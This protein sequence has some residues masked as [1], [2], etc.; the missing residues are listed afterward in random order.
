[1]RT[2][3]NYGGGRQTV[4]ICCLIVEGK[5]PQ[6]DRIVMADTNR[7]KGSTW[8]YLHQ[9]VQ[10]MLASIGMAVEVAPHSLAKVDLYSHNGDLLLPVFTATGKFSAYCSSEWKA[11]VVNRYLGGEDKKRIHWIGFSYDELKRVKSTE[12]KWFPLI[13]KM[14]TSYDCTFITARHG[15]PPAPRSACWMCPNMRNS[16]WRHVRDFLPEQFAMAC[17]LDDDIRAEDLANGGT[18]VWL[19]ATLVPLRDADLNARDS[20]DPIRQCALGLCMV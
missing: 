8:D 9:H 7:E 6:P 17:E 13:D 4:A 16:E 12:G 19:H 15:L 5:L 18:G 20:K 11:R 3:L 2:V 10:P 1:M 14:L